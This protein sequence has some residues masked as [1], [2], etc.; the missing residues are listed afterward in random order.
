MRKFCAAVVS[1]VLLGARAIAPSASAELPGALAIS[2]SALQRMEHAA[3]DYRDLAS[4]ETWP[5]FPD[6][7]TLRLGDSDPRVPELGRLLSLVGDLA[8]ASVEQTTVYGP[9]LAEAVRSFQRRH[10]LAPDAVVGRNT[11]AALATSPAELAHT[12]SINV[13]RLRELHGRLAPDA[14]VVNIPAFALT[15]F[16]GGEPDWHTRIIVGKPSWRTPTF[17]SAITRVELNPYWNV[18]PSIARRELAPLI[19]RDLGYLAQHDMKVL[20]GSYTGPAVDP[21]SVEWRRFSASEYRL[22]Q[23]PGPDNPLGQVKFQIPNPFD[24]Y[25]HDTPGKR[26]FEL[27]MRALSHGCIRVQNAMELAARLLA[28]EPGWNAERLGAEAATGRNMQIP[29]TRPVPVAVVYV[30][31]WVDPNG[32]VQFRPDLYRKDARPNVAANPESCGSGGLG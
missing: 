30:T 28:V 32:A 25:L 3:A 2:E 15:V 18:P 12:L 9:D 20:R 4:R 14:I 23:D 13:D 21:A 5:I 1:C 11:R 19:A 7:S 8:H 22:R 29:L 17:D 26:S 16:K 6:G 10:G 24:V 31:A 27:D